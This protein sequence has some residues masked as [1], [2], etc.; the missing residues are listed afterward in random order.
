MND[1]TDRLS[2]SAEDYLE[3]I[4]HLCEEHG[5]AHVGDIADRLR[6]KK[7]SV[8]V[9]MRQLAAGGYVE[10]SQYAPVQLTEAGWEYARR[11]IAAHQALAQLLLQA[12]LSPDRAD[13]VA[14]EI[15]HI[16]T[17]DEVTCVVRS[18][19]AQFEQKPPQGV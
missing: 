19:S 18:L 1:S 8:T 10:Y 5:H 4:G 9:A 16:M 2:R 12:G 3:A 11:V 17:S 7:P 15:E 6:V 13:R 14:C